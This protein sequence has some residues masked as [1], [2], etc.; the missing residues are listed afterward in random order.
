MTRFTRELRRLEE[1]GEKI[2]AEELERLRREVRE[3][4]LKG[5]IFHAESL[6]GI[7]KYSTW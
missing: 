5:E 7:I 6:A 3:E 2:I 4:K 1:E